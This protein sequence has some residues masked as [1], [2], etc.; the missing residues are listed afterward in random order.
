MTEHQL[1]ETV[2]LHKPSGLPFD[3]ASALLL[4]PHRA[5]QDRSGI[6]LMPS[7]FTNYNC[8]TP[9]ETGASGLIVFTKDWTIKR[10][11]VQDARHNEHEFIVEVAG[12]VL[13]ENLKALNCRNQKVSISKQNEKITGLRFA[14]KDFE[15]GQIAADCAR[16]GLAIQAIKRLRIGRLSVAGLEAEQWRFLMGYEQF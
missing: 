15:P 16:A 10:K 11:M 7:H 14:L 12:E 13:Q 6:V 4:P 5:R 9:L 3:Q 2:L 8:V 1:I